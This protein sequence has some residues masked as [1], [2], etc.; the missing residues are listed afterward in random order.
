MVRHFTVVVAAALCMA[1]PVGADDT[2]G[3]GGESRR[4]RGPYESVRKQVETS[5]VLVGQIVPKITVY[6][7]DAE[8]APLSSTWKD[9]PALIVTASITCP[10]AKRSCPSLVLK[11][12]DFGDQVNAV[13]LYTIE[14]HPR[15]G[16]SPYDPFKGKRSQF[17]HDQPDTLG[18]RLELARAFAAGI[19]GVPVLVDKMSNEAWRELGGGPNMAV[20]VDRQGRIAAKQGWFDP[21]VMAA[22]IEKLNVAEAEKDNE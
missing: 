3:T 20:L 5:G 11:E 21:K 19:E 13:I 9:K 16:R 12:H 15:D 2:Q 4:S 6:T 8:S 7:L 10:I 14:A 1:W 17:S 22:E 18:Q